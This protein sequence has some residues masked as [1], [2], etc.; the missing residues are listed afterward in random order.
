MSKHLRGREAIWLAGAPAPRRATIRLNV[1]SMLVF[2][3]RPGLLPCQH[4]CVWTLSQVLETEHSEECVL[5]FREFCALRRIEPKQR[6]GHAAAASHH[7]TGA[8]Q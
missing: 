4:R 2:V 6:V 3:R 1:P 8:K 7:Q 5:A